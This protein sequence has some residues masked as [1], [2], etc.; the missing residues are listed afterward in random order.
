MRKFIIFFITSLLAVVAHAYTLQ[1]TVRDAATGEAIEF[2][3]VEI[4]LESRTVLTDVRGRYSVNVPA[5]S[6]VVKVSFIG[7]KS[8]TSRVSLS[9]NRTL[10]FSLSEDSQLLEEVVVTAKEQNGLTSTSRIDREAMTHLQPTSF[11]DLLELLPG[12]ISQNPD[13]GSVNSIQ[14]R[15][16]GNLTATGTQSNSENYAISS[17]G[18]LFVVDGAPINGDANMQNI[19]GASSDASSPEYKKDMT[20]RGVDMRT[21]STD[22][23]ESVEIVR[24]IPSVEYGNLTSGM[25]NI[26][27]VRRATPVTARFKADEYSKLVSVGKG[28][29]LGKSD[30]IMN[31]DGSYLDSKVDP[32]NNLENY[33]RV[34]LSGRLN[35]RFTSPGVETTWIT[36]V[37]YTGSFDNSKTDPDL[38]AL[39]V[40][41][42]KSS[43][44]RFNYTGDLTFNLTR[45]KWL[46]R[47]NL[48]TSVS[49]QR[50][51]LERNKQVAPQRASVAPTSMEEGV[52]DGQYLLN[53]YIAHYVSDGKPLNLFL[54]L[55]GEGDWTARKVSGGYKVGGEWTTSKNYGDGQVYDLSRPLSASWVTRPRAYKDIPAL[56]VLSFYGE[57]NIKVPMGGNKLEVQAGL[58]SIQLVGLDSRYHLSG[59]PYLDPRVNAKWD[60]PAVAIGSRQ[61]RLSLSG[62]YGV[63][64]KM[65]TVSHLFPQV[66]YNDFIQLNYYDVLNPTEHSRVSLRTYIDDVTNYRLKP[67]INHKWEVRLAGE[68][69]KNHFSVTYFKEKMNSGFRNM[70]YYRPYEYTK[71]DAN[72]IH[73]EYVTAPPALDTI[74]SVTTTV[75]DGYSMVSNGS[76]LDKEGVEF[77]IGLAR[78]RP[79]ATALTITGAWFH[80][81][82]TNSLMLYDPVSD[83]VD[84]TPVRNNYIGYYNYNDG[85]V[86]DRF[87][88]NFMFDTQISRWGLVFTTTVQCMWWV[89]T[90]KLRQNGVPVSYLDVADGQLHPYTEASQSDP[91]LQFLTRTYN[92]SLYNRLTT[93]IA[94]YV[95]LKATKQVGKHLKIAVFANRLLDYLPDYK[96][97]GLMVR[98]TSDPYFGMELNFSL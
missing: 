90:R 77:V 44:N 40:N 34:T 68:I 50:D 78:W 52:H 38:S 19:P 81:T 6:Y 59:R 56:N 47:I 45:L 33:K 18:T 32:R 66:H 4:S 93:P 8:A 80:S 42:Y 64:T 63:T 84:G 2:A 87:N 79:L 43:Y 62:G 21:I 54:K 69:G 73:A 51:R 98:R 49:Y 7:Y 65:P 71:Y 24:G 97:N 82:Y 15:E 37:D 14:L 13:M 48:N 26:K 46:K 96:S 67:A 92:E 94:M 29:H 36:G 20:N 3:Q 74:P 25:V 9:G 10:N 61:L 76:R 16:T 60:F 1:G 28:F 23:I 95:N 31:V 41:E 27:R 58:R 89:S 83:V 5:G 11:T 30:H 85:R 70:S 22:N 12:N 53:D 88:T 39:K 72:G 17:L 75:L 55:K 57:G 35:L 91:V 86:N